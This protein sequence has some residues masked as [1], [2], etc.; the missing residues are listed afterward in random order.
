MIRY[1]GA[2]GLAMQRRIDSL[3]ALKIFISDVSALRLSLR[4]DGTGRS[5]NKMSTVWRRGDPT[6][7]TALAN[8][9][10]E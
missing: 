6:V 2:R 8:Q 5:L 10:D 4:Q 1:K 9:W 7:H 3:E